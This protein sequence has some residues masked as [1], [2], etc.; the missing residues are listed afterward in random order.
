M[1]EAAEVLAG[2]LAAPAA[3]APV[4]GAGP[5]QRIEMSQLAATSLDLRILWLGGGSAIAKGAC[6]L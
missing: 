4:S 1:A 2:V 6:H 3:A 5:Q